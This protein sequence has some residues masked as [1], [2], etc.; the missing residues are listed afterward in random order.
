[1]TSRRQGL[2][3]VAQDNWIDWMGIEIL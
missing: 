1:M 2:W 3:L